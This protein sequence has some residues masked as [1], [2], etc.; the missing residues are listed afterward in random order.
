MITKNR[1]YA[2]PNG[3]SLDEDLPRIQNGFKQIDKDVTLLHEKVD[4]GLYE[5]KKE[6]TSSQ[7][8]MIALIGNLALVNFER[9]QK[10]IIGVQV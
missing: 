6:A 3:V 4:K 7:S 5:L 1:K 2:L 9:T 8:R 10:I